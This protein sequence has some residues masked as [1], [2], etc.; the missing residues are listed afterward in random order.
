M[1]RVQ[2]LDPANSWEGLSLALTD[3]AGMAEVHARYLG[4]AKK[5]DVMSF[6]YPPTP[7]VAEGYTGDVIVNVQLAMEE[8]DR[9]E[10]EA[11]ELALYIAHGCHHLTGADDATPLQRRQMRA[12]ETGWL[13][14]AAAVGLIEPILGL[15]DEHRSGSGRSKIKRKQT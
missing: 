10:G 13:T 7:C 14:Q 9:H 6:A 4:S 2:E 15:P 8:G 11:W 12:V 3:H 5:T 1:E